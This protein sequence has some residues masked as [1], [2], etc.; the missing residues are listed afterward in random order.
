M[1]DDKAEPLF[2]LDV[3]DEHR[4]Q[5]F[6]NLDDSPDGDWDYSLVEQMAGYMHDDPEGI[7]ST[8]LLFRRYFDKEFTYYDELPWRE[9]V[10]RVLVSLFGYSVLSTAKDAGLIEENDDE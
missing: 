1:S 9:V 8:N 2:T 7:K 10:D 6:K 5:F 4:K 3:T